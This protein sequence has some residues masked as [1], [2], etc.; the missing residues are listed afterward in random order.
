MPNVSSRS[1]SSIN[2]PIEQAEEA[3]QSDRGESALRGI[4]LYYVS[5]TMI[6]QE[7]TTDTIFGT[8]PGRNLDFSQSLSHSSLPKMQRECPY[9]S[10]GSC[11]TK[12][13]VNMR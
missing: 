7:A 6:P 2:P 13:K 5:A 10:R 11:H 8:K 1:E 12:G 3:R 9:I 4:P